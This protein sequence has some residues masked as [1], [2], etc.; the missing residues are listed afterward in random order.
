MCKIFEAHG[1][2]VGEVP[3][4]TLRSALRSLGRT[5]KDAGHPLEL[6]SIRGRFQLRPRGA[7]NAPHTSKAR[8]V[9][10]DAPVVMAKDTARTVVV[11]GRLP[12]ESLYSLEWAARWWEAYSG[13]EAAIRAPYEVEAWHKLGIASR[14]RKREEEP[15]CIVGLAP[16][17]GIGEIAILKMILRNGEST[18]SRIHYLAVDSSPRL[19]RDHIGLL[20][21]T[22][23]PEI[24]S[25]RLICA[26]VVT[27]IFIGLTSAIAEVQ[28]EFRRRGPLSTE[29]D[30]LHTSWPMLVTY[31]GNCLG[32]GEPDR[33]D[34]FFSTVHSAFPN[35]PLELLVGVSVMREE[36]DEY[37]RTWDEFLL[38]SLHHLLETS[39]SLESSQPN[40]SEELPEFTLPRLL[41]YNR[42]ENKAKYLEAKKTRDDRCPPVIARP[43]FTSSDIEGQIYS[44]EY[45]LTYDLGIPD[46]RV[47]KRPKGS[48]VT[49]YN[50]IKYK[51]PT[52][53][54]GIKKGGIFKKVKYLPDF[55]QAVRTSNGVR[56]YA[57]FSAYFGK[58]GQGK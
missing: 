53:V 24:E 55:H 9:L 43:Y 38:Q 21:E 5:L 14:L 17:E 23:A 42:E 25:G 54:E 39:K 32:N 31:L 30:F 4:A 1:V 52:L 49:L 45:R 28:D 34:R 56:E 6:R 15:M 27:D 13:E 51:M 47:H 46:E 36:S 44:F 58:Q 16:G 20:R 3:D 11:N 2:I 19:L 41:D 7:F 40:Q 10:L 50:V 22:L 8:V 18:P 29:D 37:D 12:F 35:R 57:V 33:E 48:R 26:G